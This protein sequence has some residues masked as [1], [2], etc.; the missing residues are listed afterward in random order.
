MRYGDQASG[1]GGTSTA[2]VLTHNELSPRQRSA[3]RLAPQGKGD[4]GRAFL[5][6]APLLEQQEEVAPSAPAPGFPAQRSAPTPFP[7][8]AQQDLQVTS[9]DALPRAA[10]RSLSVR[11]PATGGF[12]A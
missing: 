4:C 8:P 1:G 9:T 3:E 2:P 6:D 12:S 5:P 7:R 11:Q 10:S